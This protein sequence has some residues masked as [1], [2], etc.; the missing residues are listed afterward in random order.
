MG[1]QTKTNK[2]KLRDIVNEIKIDANTKL[3]LSTLEEGIYYSQIGTRYVW[4]KSGTEFLLSLEDSELTEDQYD[5]LNPKIFHSRAYRDE[6]WGFIG[7]NRDYVQIID[8]LQEIKIDAV[9]KLK[10]KKIGLRRYCD[11]QGYIWSKDTKGLYF[12]SYISNSWNN[13]DYDKLEPTDFHPRAY[14]SQYIYIDPEY[15]QIVDKLNEIKIDVT[16]K[17]L[18]EPQGDD[19]FLDKNDYWWMLSVSRSN[20]FL[21]KTRNTFPI[22][23]HHLNSTDF[24]P[25]AYWDGEGYIRLD[26]RYV[27]IVK[28]LNEIKISTTQIYGITVNDERVEFEDKEILNLSFNNLKELY[29]RSSKVKEISCSSCKLTRLTLYCPSLEILHCADN[30]LT[31]LDLSRCP[32]LKRL[33][34]YHNNLTQLDV[35]KCPNLKILHHGEITLIGKEKTQLQ[36]IKIKAIQPIQL[37]KDGEWEDNIQYVDKKTGWIWNQEKGDYDDK[38]TT[39]AVNRDIPEITTILTTRNIPYE[40][41]E[42]RGGKIFTVDKK[43][44]QISLQEDEDMVQK[45]IRLDREGVIYIKGFKDNPSIDTTMKSVAEYMKKFKKSFGIDGGRKK[46]EDTIELLGPAQTK[47]KASKIEQYL[48]NA[49]FTALRVEY[50]IKPL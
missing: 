41:I 46:D 19:L 13:E 1:R 34:C 7:L 39:L 42:M 43:Y 48:K 4:F 49:G 14:W 18:L 28:K 3:K 30:K 9:P 12:L 36:E 33:D 15:V 37:I 5:N 44:F 24:H 25:K 20:Y 23:Y 2:M 31:T 45:R 47:A 26:T 35:S 50:K 16:P 27:Q 29:V 17:F 8:K 21:S 32:L 6:Q 40:E 22:S 10:L 38:L 11:K